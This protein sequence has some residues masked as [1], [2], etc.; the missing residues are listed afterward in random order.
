MRKTFFFSQGTH[1]FE[2]PEG[3]VELPPTLKLD[4]WKRPVDFLPAERVTKKT[5]DRNFY[6]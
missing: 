3:K 4:Q 6:L 2:D 5:N 1:G